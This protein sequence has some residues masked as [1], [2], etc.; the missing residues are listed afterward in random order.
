MSRPKVKTALFAIFAAIGLVTIAFSTFALSRLDVINSNV[1]VLAT[2]WM[3]SLQHAKEMDTA[4][5]D[6]IG[7]YNRHILA[8]SDAD[9]KEAEESVIREGKRFQTELDSYGAL[10]N[11]GDE[12]TQAIGEIHNFYK[13]YGQAGEAMLV[14]SRASKDDEAKAATINSMTPI[15]KK[16]QS[17]IDAVVAI[18]MAGSKAAYQAS[19][20][21]FSSTL[22]VTITAV[23]GIVVLIAAATYFAFAQI[24]RPIEKITNTMRN[25]AT[26]DIDSVVPFAGRSDE[27]GDMAAAVEIF[28][29]NAIRAQTLESDSNDLRNQSEAE[30]NRNGALEAVKTQAMQHATSDLAKGLRQLAAGD[31]T[32]RL[33]TPFA[34]DFESLRGDFNGAVTQLTE[35]LAIVAQ[36][37]H[38]IDSG[39]REISQS[40]DDLSKRT[41]NQAASLEQTAAALDEITVNVSNSSK[42][43][44]EARKVVAEANASASHSGAVVA[45]TVSAMQK[46]EHSSKQ[47][48]TIIG[49]IDE[50]AFQTNLLALN[51]GVEAARAGEAGRG[52]A[53]VAQEVRELAQRSAKAA[54]EI[55]DLIRNSSVEVQ[56]GV[57]LVNETGKALKTIEGFIVTINEHMQSIATSAKEQA[58]GLEEVNTAVNQMDQVTQQ[59]AAMVEET[60]AASATL[61]SESTRL[62][63]VVQRFHLADGAGKASASPRRAETTVRRFPQREVRLATQGNLA[64]KQEWSEF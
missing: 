51:A 5:S 18:N 56:S 54:K 34:A 22:A 64:I 38:S 25:L 53:V 46:I 9:Q 47:I 16:I 24:A 21:V 19:Q 57:Q 42:R 50:I 35:T 7:A 40:S 15:S 60:S 17:D 45:T 1:A 41:E 52:F 63:E 39:S 23:F 3:P 27:I 55:K 11:P 26:G 20:K 30:R 59:N 37:A 13:S 33:D 48:A 32:V 8:V 14:F 44:E 58:L 10:M 2:D 29:S 4:M 31:L 28:R 49:V 12:E 43:A 36:S 62:R 61:S 6:M